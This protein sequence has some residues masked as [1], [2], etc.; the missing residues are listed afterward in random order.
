MCEIELKTE[1]NKL[2]EKC[3]AYCHRPQ[4][5]WANSIFVKDGPF[6][7]YEGQRTKILF[8]G[9]EL[10]GKQN[11]EDGLCIN[12][13]DERAGMDKLGVFQSR[14]LYLAYGIHKREC[15]LDDWL[16]MK[17]AKE[18]NKLFANEGKPFDDQFSYAFMNA[19]KILNTKSTYVGKDFQ[20]FIKD[21]NNR[22]F[23]IREIEL[24]NPDIIIS[25][26]LNDLSFFTDANDFYQEFKGKIEANRE[27]Q[28][29]NENCFVWQY[30]INN[31]KIPWLD[32]YHFSRRGDT[33]EHFYE[34]ICKAAKILL[35]KD[36]SAEHIE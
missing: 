3:A 32:A 18:L 27:S 4:S 15:G 36:E 31:K 13:W 25:G 26:N 24:I 21:P 12:Y 17:E 20:E 33:F 16:N 6:P 19:C 8:I 7:Q 11:K 5:L 35:G 2:M 30:K 22:V 29:H 1:I 9:R 28:F 14:L 10:Y 23:F 34:P